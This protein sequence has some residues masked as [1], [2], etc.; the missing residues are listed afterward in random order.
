LDEAEFFKQY[1][2][3]LYLSSIYDLI[4]GCPSQVV[5]VTSFFSKKK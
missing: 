3:Y 4:Q 2:N 5:F 1:L